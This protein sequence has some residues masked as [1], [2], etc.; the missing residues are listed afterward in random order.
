MANILSLQINS[1]NSLLAAEQLSFDTV[2]AARIAE[3][4]KKCKEAK[5]FEFSFHFVKMI[6]IVK[7]T[8]K[9]IIIYLVQLL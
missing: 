9:F 4:G 7:K 1:N 3:E 8:L 2:A 6:N 5:G